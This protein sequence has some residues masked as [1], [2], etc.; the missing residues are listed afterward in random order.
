MAALVDL[1]AKVD[2]NVALLGTDHYI[3]VIKHS[4]HTHG[5]DGKANP[6]PIILD[7]I[8]DI[9]ASV[10]VIAAIKLTL[11]I[12]DVEISACVDL[13]VSILLVRQLIGRSYNQLTIRLAEHLHCALEIQHSCSAYRPRS[14]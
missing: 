12:L 8:A 13:C 1:K 7:I 10:K 9:N 14:T 2:A 3:S 11:P 6:I 5:T 4:A